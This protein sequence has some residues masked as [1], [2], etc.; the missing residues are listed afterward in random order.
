MGV[1]KEENLYYQYQQ[2]FGSLIIRIALGVRR[3]ML[4]YLIQ[5]TRPTP[6]TTVLDVGVTSYRREEC[7]FFERLYPYPNK[8]TAVGMEDACFLEQEYP[9]LKFIRC[10]GAKL[11]FP[12][13]SFDLVVSFATVEHVGGKQQQRA[14]IYELC[15]VGRTCCITIPNRWYPIEFH[16]LLPFVHWLPRSLFRSVC[17]LAG[18]D[19]FAKEE[20]LNLLSVTEALSLFPEDSKVHV[21]YFRLFCFV[22]N[23][24]FYVDN[25]SKQ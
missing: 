1:E 5:I 7:N 8:I 13:K 4:D 12:D 6:E 20:N 16:T 15:R 19:F 11:P 3:K 18:R 9:G 14:F 23:F 25:R 21:G 24:M 2:I 10:N 22:S 17:R